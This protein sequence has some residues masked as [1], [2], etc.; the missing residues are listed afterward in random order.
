MKWTLSTAHKDV[1]S[2][3]PYLYA[4]TGSYDNDDAL[5]LGENRW[6]LLLQAAYIHYFNE[7]WALNTAADVSWFSHN[8]D[9]GPGSA[10]LEQKTRYEYQAY[11]RYNLSPQTHFALGG[12]YI[13]GGE[14]RVGGINQD[15][16]LS[17]TYI[18][19]S[20]THMLTTSVQIQAVIGRD[21]EVEQGF[22]RSPG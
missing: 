17:T 12:G 9:Y 18:R 21:V 3:A 22:R 10:T 8:T 13:N 16:R 4:P 11:L 7:K 19:M 15:D 1:F 6:R 5:N 14:N 2:L 20:A